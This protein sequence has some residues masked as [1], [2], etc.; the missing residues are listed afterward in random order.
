MCSNVEMFGHILDHSLSFM[1]DFFF[2]NM[3][4]NLVAHFA[5]VVRPLESAVDSC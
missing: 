1:L 5:E 2:K 3:L 4:Y